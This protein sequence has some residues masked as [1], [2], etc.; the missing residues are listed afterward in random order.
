MTSKKTWIVAHRGDHREQIENTLPAFAEAFAHGAKMVECDVQLS[1]DLVPVL[2]H[3]DDLSRFHPAQRPVYYYTRAELASFV[4]KEDHKEDSA[5]PTLD[6]YLRHFAHRPT[7]FELKVPQAKWD[8]SEY[9]ENLCSQTLKVL[10][11]YSLDANSFLASFH[12]AIS[13]TLR[14]LKSPFQFVKI[15]ESLDE[16]HHYFPNQ[17]TFESMLKSEHWDYISISWKSIFKH[18]PADSIDSPEGIPTSKL[19]IWDILGTEFLQAQNYPFQ[20][21]VSDNFYLKRII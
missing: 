1:Y 3:D 8:D 9:I 7:Y 6:Q 18:L 15:I 11:Q 12:P 4:L 2:F 20:G 14:R 17:H 10:K 13:S 21:L 5:I 16:F 19:Y